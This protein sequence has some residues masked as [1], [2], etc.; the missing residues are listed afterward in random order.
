MPTSKDTFLYQISKLIPR[1]KRYALVLTSVKED[2]DDLLQAT[3][4]RAIAKQH[5]W[6]KNSHLDR[7]VFTIMSSL[8]KNEIRSRCTRQGNGISHNV[9]ELS[10]SS[11]LETLEGTFLYHQVFKEVMKLSEN[12]REAILLVY[13]EGL[14]YQEA[15]DILAIPAG[16]L[17]S[18]L[19][20][21][22]LI[23]ANKLSEQSSDKEQQSNIIKFKE[24]KG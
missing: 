23:L 14:K 21:A 8:W 12:Q 24:H 22:R 3:L 16:T 6:Q 10:N 9:Q 5:Q 18:R 19:A 1:L 15:A 2:A 13:V 7:W 11:S 20:R 17:M 4:E